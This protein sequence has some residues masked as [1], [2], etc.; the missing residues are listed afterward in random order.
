MVYRV[1][2]SLKEKRAEAIIARRRKR[3]S[4]KMIGQALGMSENHA[5]RLARRIAKERGRQVFLS[6]G[7][8]QLYT[9]SESARYLRISNSAFCRL[10][11]RVKFPCVW[12]RK[13]IRRFVRKTV[14]EQL[15]EHPLISGCYKCVVCREKIPVRPGRR[16]KT[17]RNI[18]CRKKYEAERLEDKEGLIA[19]LS[20][21]TKV[22]WRSLRK[23]RPEKNDAWVKLAEAMRISG[24]TMK[25]VFRLARF[26]L[27]SRRPIKKGGVPGLTSYSLY[28]LSEMRVIRKVMGRLRRR[29][30]FF[31]P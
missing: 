11:N 14:L 3:Q 28:F 17:C 30:I 5:A 26:G 2:E 29:K 10:Y 8:E 19:N 13:G 16:P 22:A 12:P 31:A 15:R 20:G 27:I 21:W 25:Q 1:Q 23:N 6:R 9:F 24:L 4:F 7:G 18:A